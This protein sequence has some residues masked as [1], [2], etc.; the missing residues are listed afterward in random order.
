[1]EKEFTTGLMALVTRAHGKTMKCM[2]RVLSSGKMEDSFK[3]LSRV[4]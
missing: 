3:G 2:A 4:A 1:M